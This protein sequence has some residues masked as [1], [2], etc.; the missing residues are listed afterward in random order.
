MDRLAKYEIQP[1]N[2]HT[3]T[4]INYS[5]T[6]YTLTFLVA[7]GFLGDFPPVDFLAVCLV[8]AMV[9]LLVLFAQ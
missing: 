9:V 5:L 2:K 3:Q 1:Q 6:S 7:I 4:T 8:R